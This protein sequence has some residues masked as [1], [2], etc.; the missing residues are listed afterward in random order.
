MAK[1]DIVKLHTGH[2]G[3]WVPAIVT[4]DANDEGKHW[5]TAFPGPAKDDESLQGDASPVLAAPGQAR[6][7]F[8]SL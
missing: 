4:S 2:D 7:E 6:Y 5:V 1:G 8:T 3:E